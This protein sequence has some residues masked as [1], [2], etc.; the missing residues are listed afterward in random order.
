MSAARVENETTVAANA[1]EKVLE[2]FTVTP[3]RLNT[4]TEN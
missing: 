2:K 4:H 1:V 3:W